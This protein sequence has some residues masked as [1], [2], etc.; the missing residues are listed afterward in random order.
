MFALIHQPAPNAM[1]SGSHG[2]NKWVIDFPKSMKTAT[3]PLTGT[4]SSIDMLKE[5]NL[6]FET[7]EAAI[8]YAK[9]KGMA[10]RVVE[11]PAHKPVGRSYADNFSYG[12]KFP[13]TH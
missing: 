4:A 12:R 7:K 8:A 1:Q 13:W 9:S 11:K 10:Y 5:L 3:D 2:Y 6:H